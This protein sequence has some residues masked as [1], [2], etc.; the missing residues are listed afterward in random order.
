LTG[1]PVL[2]GSGFPDSAFA[3][4]CAGRPV[5]AGNDTYNFENLNNKFIV[6]LKLVV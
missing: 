5:V 6:L 2:K 3:D 1:D 4:K